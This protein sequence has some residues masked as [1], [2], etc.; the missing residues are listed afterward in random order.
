MNTEESTCEQIHVIV[1]ESSQVGEA[2]RRVQALAIT[3]RIGRNP[4]GD[5]ALIATEMGTNLVKLT[6]R[7]G[8]LFIRTLSQPQAQS[9]EIVD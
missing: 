2:R 4:C 1:N 9:N 6:A 3:D 8:E 5:Q 7:D